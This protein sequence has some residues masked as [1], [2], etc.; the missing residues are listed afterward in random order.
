LLLKQLQ[1]LK[2]KLLLARDGY[3]EQ[4]RNDLQTNSA[5]V[6]FQQVTT[7][8]QYSSLCPSP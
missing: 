8:V 5:D 2:L 7:L 6:N 4:N 3:F 1:Q